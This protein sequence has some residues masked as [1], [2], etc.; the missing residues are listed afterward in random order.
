MAIQ[1]FEALPRPVWPKE[2]G[3]GKSEAASANAAKLVV[4]ST[5]PRKL[6][7]KV[8]AATLARSL[9][10]Q[11]GLTEWTFRFHARW[12]GNWC[13]YT[14]KMITLSEPLARRSDPFEVRLIMLHEIAHALVGPGHQ[15][16]DVWKAKDLE[17]GGRGEKFLRECEST[18]RPDD[19][20]A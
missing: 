3:G 9:M 7:E 2:S 6:M 4:A 16:D 15:H 10:N 14:E 17:L 18:H 20:T 1:K 19:G 5:R 13:C 8:A 12:D 11:H